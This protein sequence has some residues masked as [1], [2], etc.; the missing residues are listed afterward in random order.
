VKG[1]ALHQDQ[2]KKVDLA[3]R[4]RENFRVLVEDEWILA[5]GC[6]ILRG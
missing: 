1:C 4:C 5:V 6:G 3:S 2:N